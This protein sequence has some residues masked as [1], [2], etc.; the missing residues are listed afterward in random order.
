MADKF[1]KLAQLSHFYEKIGGVFVKKDGSKVLS[2]NNYTTAEKNKLAGIAAG[3]NAYTLPVATASALGGV[4]GGGNVA[5]SSAGV[6]SVDLSAYLTSTTASSTYYTKTQ[7]ASDLA[8]KVDV[9]SGK[10]LSTNDFTSA[11]KT[12]LAGIAAGANAYTLPIASTTKL[13]GIKIGANLSI[14]EDGTLSAAQG[15]LDTSPFETKANA[16]ATYLSKSTFNTEIAK[17]ALKSD[18]ASAVNYK[19]AA[20]SFAKLPS[21]GNKLGDMYNIK[22][23]GGTDADGVAIKAGD[24]VVYN[25]SGW[26]NYG[27]TFVID[28]ATDTDIDGIFA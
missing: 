14:T 21:T 13:G 6:L 24:N 7:A 1:I 26:D 19:G 16:S 11:E 3:A 18:I 22:A 2:D 9:V 10:G 8:K 28:A 5:I 27:G 4:K 17:Y 23:A 20:D 25:G 15:T 12:K